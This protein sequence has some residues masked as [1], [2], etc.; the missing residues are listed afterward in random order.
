M[1]QF[2]F[3]DESHKHYAAQKKPDTKKYMSYDSIYMIL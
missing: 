1:Q 3:L 2:Y